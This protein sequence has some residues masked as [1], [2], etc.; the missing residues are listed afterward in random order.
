MLRIGS[1][2]DDV[3]TG[4]PGQRHRRVAQ[5]K[6]EPTRVGQGVQPTLGL[7]DPGQDDLAVDDHRRAGA[8]SRQLK[9]RH[10]AGELRED[11]GGVDGNPGGLTQAAS[12]MTR[13]M[14][15]PSTTTQ[16]ASSSD[17][18]GRDSVRPSMA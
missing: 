13:T 11:G 1:A 10:R 3:V 7:L 9:F 2:D 4:A 17:Q 18:L 12:W 14:L 15:L 6:S 16:I 5:T 8:V